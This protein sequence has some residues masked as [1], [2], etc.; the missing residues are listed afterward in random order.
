MV[1]LDE[2]GRPSFSLLQE[3]AGLHGLGSHHG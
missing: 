3:L 1:A 2:D